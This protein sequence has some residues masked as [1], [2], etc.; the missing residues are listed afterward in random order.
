MADTLLTHDMLAERLL[1]DLQNELSFSAHVYKGYNK[2]FTEVG[3]FKKGNS[4]RIALPV[5]FRT[6]NG[7]AIDIVDVNETNTTVTVDVQRHVAWD[8]TEV[9]LTQSVADASG[10][11]LRPAA[12]ALANI[13]D[14]LGCSEYVNIY[15]H[16]GTPGTAPSTFG[17][18]ADAAERMDNE[19]I[20]REGR[21]AV[22]SPRAYW[23][24]ADG[25]LKSVFQPQIVETLVRKG[26]M[27][28]FAGFDFFMDQ[29][30]QAHTTGVFTTSATPVM[31][32]ATAEAATTLV[33]DGWNAT[34]S[35]LTQ[36]DI[37]TVAAV[38][39]V[40]PVSGDVWENSVL[41]QFVVTADVTST[42]GG[43]MTIAVSPT[44]YSSAATEKVLPYQT[45]DTLPANE[46]SITPVG[47]ESTAYAQ[48]L[49]FH[50]NAFALTVV[51]Y[52]RPMSAGQSVMWGQASDPQ[53]GLAITVS[54]GFDIDAFDETTRADVLFGWDTIQPE[55]AVR[56]TG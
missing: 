27:G 5:K 2:E 50:P 55:Y 11:Y 26:F 41:R 10:R 45:I 17:V 47:T 13:I 22:L 34:S 39:G 43:D 53:L 49:L 9:E 56:L 8:F 44:I 7:I 4:V 38:S 21:V 12:I 16:V 30:I 48:N 14:N 46:G 54:T 37:I 23:A 42:G 36:G 29:N 18:L 1:F 32:G 15:N 40:N 3:R 35:T 28:R 52:Q 31:N 24:L 51:P 25:E 33:T 20:P 6:K 19:A